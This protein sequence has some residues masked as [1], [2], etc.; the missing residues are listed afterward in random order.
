MA[1][2]RAR[3]RS[4][5]LVSRSAGSFFWR[6]LA[7]PEHSIVLPLLQTKKHVLLL[8]ALFFISKEMFS[9]MFIFVFLQCVLT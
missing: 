2:A 9:L 7:R 6:R 1:C 5:T 8:W 4:R 3:A